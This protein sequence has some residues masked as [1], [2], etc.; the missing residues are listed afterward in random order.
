MQVEI[1]ISSFAHSPKEKASL[2]AVKTAIEL[3]ETQH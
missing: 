3:P 1:V 2:V